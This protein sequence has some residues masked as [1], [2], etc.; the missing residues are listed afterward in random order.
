MSLLELHREELKYVFFWASYP[1]ISVLKRK[2]CSFHLD[3]PCKGEFICFSSL[4]FCSRISYKESIFI[5]FYI[6][7]APF[8]HRVYIL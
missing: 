3:F 7:S 4:C 1:A 2:I 5:I 6:N 8:C